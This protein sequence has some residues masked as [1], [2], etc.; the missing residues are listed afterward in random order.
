LKNVVGQPDADP[1]HAVADL[2]RAVSA[3]RCCVSRSGHGNVISR[4]ERPPRAW[5]LR[6]VRCSSR[7]DYPGKGVGCK[8]GVPF[9]HGP[10]KVACSALIFLGKQSLST[11]PANP[12]CS[13]FVKGGKQGDLP[14]IERKARNDVRNVDVTLPLYQGGGKEAFCHESCMQSSEPSPPRDDVE[15]RRSQPY[16]HDAPRL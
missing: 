1:P 14:G 11:F 8:G 9:T 12:P 4:P 7:W 13:P 5:T 3:H 6:V 15:V 16:R 2:Q 10:V